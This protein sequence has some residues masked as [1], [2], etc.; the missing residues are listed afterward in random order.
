MR[1]STSLPTTG[2]SKST[3]LSP[4]QALLLGQAPGVA[5]LLQVLE[6]RA[7]LGRERGLDHH[8]VAAHVDDVVDV[9][10]VDRALL[11]AGA[12]GGAGPQDVRVDD[13]VLFEGADQRA[14]GLGER[15]GGDVLR[16][17]PRSPSRRPP[18]S[19]PPPASR[20]GALACAWSRSDMISSFGESGLPVFQ[21]GHCDWQRP[22]SVQV[23]K[24]SRPFQEKCSTWRDAEDVVLA[25]VL[26]VDLLAAAGHRLQR[27]ERR[28]RRPPRA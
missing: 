6:H 25:R 17:A 23:E 12:A 13:A 2:T 22:H 14:L 11:D 26:E 18:S 10:D 27:A 16:A 5:L 3:S 4:L 20:Y 9:L 28:R 19:L 21:A 7:R 24:S 15:R 1:S 8:L